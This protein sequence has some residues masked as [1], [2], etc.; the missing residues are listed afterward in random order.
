MKYGFDQKLDRSGLSTMKWEMEQ[1]RLNDPDLLCFGTAEMDF[2]AA[3]PILDAFQK[4]VDNGH[5][6]Y[7]YKRPSYYDAVTDWF[8]RHCGLEIK[9]E[10]IANSVAIYP[11]FQGLIEG[12][13]DE[14]DEVI[15]NTPVHFIF[16]DIVKS[17]NRVPVE[18]P[19]TVRDGTYVIDYA[20]LERKI[21][22]KT[23]LFILCNP[24][25]PVGRAWTKEELAK[26]TDICIKHKIIII[27][28]EVYFGLIY[29]GKA[30]TPIISVSEAAAMN[31]VTCISPTKSFNLTGVK[32]SLVIAKDPKI[33]EIYKQELHKNNEFFGESIFGHAA[34][35][36]AFGRCDEWSAQ[37]MDYIQGNYQTVRQFVEK[38][39]PGVVLYEPD[40]T[41]FLWMDFNCYHMSPEQQTTVFE[42]EARVEV[43]Q[44]HSLGT[45]GEGHIRMNIACPRSVL[46][47]GL[48]RIKDAFEKYPFERSV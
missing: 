46:L 28:D 19:L 2:K 30:Y 8:D 24:H 32:H 26:L 22:A 36:A 5:F 18:N 23:K 33:L 16:A 29:P 3:Q 1:D 25:N 9:K 39:L 12:L 17:L 31:S 34:V 13:S 7:P 10:W 37:L 45:G 20:D 21:T 11:S 43:S 14:G 44:G 15:F 27:S 48:K 6:G 4:V 40:S 41:Y 38:E 35:E 47:E 42:K